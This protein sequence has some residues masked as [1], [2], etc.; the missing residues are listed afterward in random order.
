MKLLIISDAWHPQLNGVVRTYEH[1][2]EEM[3]KTGHTCRVIGPADFPLTL[4][5]PG[6]SEIKLALFPYRRLVKMIEDFNPDHI[7]VATEGPLGWAGRRYCIKTKHAFT[8]A[9]HTQFP[10]YSAKRFAR[11]LPFLYKPVFKIAVWVVRTFHNA[12]HGMFVATNSLEQEL[13]SW[14]FTVPSHPLT[15]G[16]NLELF[17][18]LKDG[19]ETVFKGLK[20]PI[21][22]YV[23]RVAIEK[24]IEAFLEMKWHGTKVIVGDG[25]ARTE[26]TQRYKDAQFLGI[27]TGEDLA[28]HYRSAD[29][30][31]FPSKTDTFGIVLIEA[32]ASGL[33][34]AGYNVTGPADIITQPLLG[35]T[36]NDNLSQA[37]LEALSA[38]GTAEE[39]SDYVK[40]RYS[41]A[42]MA[43]QFVSPVKNI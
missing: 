42:L 23:G 3:E 33:P 35:A 2:V 28:K 12:A 27:K 25:P 20:A 11:F 31:V 7:H 39:R 13:R 4:P 22:L 37:S 10:A 15:R 6:Y 43:E 32:L 26:L 19:E 36:T 18:P 17:R 14:G 30:F 8:T 16:V 40:T 34:V 38:P 24:N 1:L 29:I 21:A 9:Y 5:M 41:W